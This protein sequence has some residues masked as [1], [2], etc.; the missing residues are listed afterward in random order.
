MTWTLLEKTT[1]HL[2]SEQ[3]QNDTHVFEDK[4][5]HAIAEMSQR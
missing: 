5:R 2:V 3:V 4:D 1:N